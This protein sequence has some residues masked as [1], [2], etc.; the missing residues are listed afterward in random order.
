MEVVC[1]LLIILLLL[2]IIIP[3][4]IKLPTNMF[5][6][7]NAFFLTSTLMPSS[8]LATLQLFMCISEISKHCDLI[9]LYFAVWIHV[10]HNE[11]T[12]TGAS[13]GSPPHYSSMFNCSHLG[14]PIPCPEQ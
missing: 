14:L 1:L 7:L 3:M 8:S 12:H 13:E 2:S 6:L 10:I 11:Y 9:C 4:L 5:H